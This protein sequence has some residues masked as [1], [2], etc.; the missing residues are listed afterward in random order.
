MRHHHAELHNTRQAPG[1]LRQA[2]PGA[3][4]MALGAA[5]SPDTALLAA[6]PRLDDLLLL[7]P[8]LARSV[9]AFRGF[10]ARQPCDATVMCCGATPGVNYPKQ[11]LASLLC[12]GRKFFWTPPATFPRRQSARPPSH[13]ARRR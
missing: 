9:R 6:D 5:D 4:L 8:G 10:M 13:P 3:R 12:P 1:Q 2:F 11:I 7:P